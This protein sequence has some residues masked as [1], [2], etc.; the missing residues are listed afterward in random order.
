MG[1]SKVPP[2]PTTANAL[3]VSLPVTSSLIVEF[4]V[5]IVHNSPVYQGRTYAWAVLPGGVVRC[6]IG[7]IS[8][9]LACLSSFSIWWH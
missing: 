5:G 2:V 4:E 3:S 1:W 8:F 7:A 6:C 9:I